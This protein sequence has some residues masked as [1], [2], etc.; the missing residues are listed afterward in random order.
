M[1]TKD[2]IRAYLAQLKAEAQDRAAAWGYPRD[3]GMV[4]GFGLTKYDCGLVITALGQFLGFRVYGK[5][6]WRCIVRP[7]QVDPQVSGS[8][9]RIAYLDHPRSSAD[10]TWFADRRCVAVFETDGRDNSPGA[11][12]PDVEPVR[13]RE[14]RGTNNLFKLSSPVLQKEFGYC[15]SIRAWV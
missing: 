2:D 3:E 9:T 1:N 7:G 15:P 12:L 14:H 4:D 6:D 13:V 11:H 5:A 8:E 10:Y